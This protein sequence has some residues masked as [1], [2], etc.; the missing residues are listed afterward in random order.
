MRTLGRAG[1]RDCWPGP[2][3]ST[4]ARRLRPQISVPRRGAKLLYAFAEAQVPRVTL[5]TR[6]SYGGAYIAMNSRSLG[7]TAV[8][9]WP[10]AEV[11]VMGAESAVCILHRRKLA[12]AV[13][14]TATSPCKSK[15]SEQEDRVHGQFPRC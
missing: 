15:V 11:A 3:P 8:Y 4:R 6:K 2:G 1:W 13:A 7:A 12:T 5:V 14:G 9:A 10:D